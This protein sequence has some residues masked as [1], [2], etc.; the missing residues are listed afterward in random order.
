[1][2]MVIPRGKLFRV[3]GSSEWK[4]IPSGDYRRHTARYPDVNQGPMGPLGRDPKGPF[5]ALWARLG[6]TVGLNADGFFERFG[7]LGKLQTMKDPQIAKT[8]PRA[9]KLPEGEGIG[10]E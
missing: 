6:G 3:E 2:R 1:M 7:A 4:A 5:G 8:T 9:E 10:F